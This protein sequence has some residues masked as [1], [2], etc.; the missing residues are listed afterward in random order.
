MLGE[1]LIEIIIY[2]NILDM[3][4]YIK[5]FLMNNILLLAYWL[6][7]IIIKAHRGNVWVNY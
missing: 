5:A 1:Q 7:G 4:K 2:F 6:S 3:D